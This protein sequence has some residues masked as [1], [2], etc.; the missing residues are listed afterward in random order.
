[1]C[2][3]IK[4][5][6]PWN[7]VLHVQKQFIHRSVPFSKPIKYLVLVGLDSKS[8]NNGSNWPVIL[9]K[10]ASSQSCQPHPFCD[11]PIWKC[12]VIIEIIHF[13]MHSMRLANWFLSLLVELT[14]HS[15][16]QEDSAWFCAKMQ[17]SCH[18]FTMS[19]CVSTR[20]RKKNRWRIC[21]KCIKM[22]KRNQKISW[23]TL[24]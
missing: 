7:W 23:Q 14:R 20:N 9:W 18:K 17:S 19:Q 15:R 13:P 1:M 5:A 24:R 21:T 11:F 16:L 22:S 2:C 12:L 4:L 6:T 10:L 8:K 3:G